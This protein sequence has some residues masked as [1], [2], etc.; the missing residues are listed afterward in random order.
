MGAFY[1]S[2]NNYTECKAV[3]IEVQYFKAMLM[4]IMVPG[5]D[6]L[7]ELGAGFSTVPKVTQGLLKSHPQPCHYLYCSSLWYLGY[8]QGVTFHFQLSTTII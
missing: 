6:A 8:F 5:K 4:D 7:C 2:A 1:N 3:E